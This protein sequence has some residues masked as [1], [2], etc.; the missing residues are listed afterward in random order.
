MVPLITFLDLSG[1]EKDELQTVIL[2]GNSNSHTC[3]YVSW[4]RGYF[5]AFT[6]KFAYGTSANYSSYGT[7]ANYST[8][9]G[10]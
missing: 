5:R 3:V 10:A 6:Y 4:M 1:G 2:P 9:T 8:Y 7:S